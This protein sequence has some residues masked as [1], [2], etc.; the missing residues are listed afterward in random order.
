MKPAHELVAGGGLALSTRE[1]EPAIVEGLG[2]TIGF[3]SQPGAG[4]T[5]HFDLPE[6]RGDENP[7]GVR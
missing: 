4:T 2:G 1:K 5:F 7:G 3:V 6:W